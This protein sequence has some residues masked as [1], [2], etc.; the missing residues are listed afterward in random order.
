MSEVHHLIRRH[1]A[2]AGSNWSIGGFGAIAE[3]IHR[4]DAPAA[5]DEYRAVSRLG[6][7]AF[8]PAVPLAP[9]AYEIPSASADYWQHGVVLCGAR[10]ISATPGGVVADLGIDAM[11]LR[12]DEAGARLFDLGVGAETFRFCVRTHAPEVVLALEAAA[13]Q[14]F[15]ASAARLVPMLLESSP[16]RVALCAAARIEVYQ[17]IAAPDG[18]TPDGPHT[19]LIPRLLRPHQTHSLNIP[20]PR[21]QVPLVTLYPAHPLTDRLGVRKPFDRAEH[22]SFQAL[23]ARHGADEAVVAKTKSQSLVRAGAP[24][25]SWAAPATRYARL[26]VRVGLRQL[27][28]SDGD[29]PALAA[30]RA[31]WDARPGAA[32]A[33]A[34]IH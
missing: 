24:A 15:A 8:D 34:A 13:G 4:P 31:R 32:G 7:I 10:P 28:H 17:P 30:W 29:S 3:F 20:V 33:P 23:F 2:D 5:I 27:R 12:A 11:A 14:A 18:Q 22:S 6:A 25:Q 9:I 19:H 1:L 21:G 26:A 16:T